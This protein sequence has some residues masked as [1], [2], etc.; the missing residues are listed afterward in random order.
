M[1]CRENTDLG[2][3]VLGALSPGERSALERHLADCADCKEELVLLAPLPGLLRHT[4]LGEVH[5]G[6]RS[7][8]GGS[9]PP[10][11]RT[12]LGAVRRRTVLVVTALL[13][14]V[15]C[16]LV[17]VPLPGDEPRAGGPP[18]AVTLSNT[19]PETHVRA[20]VALAAEAWGTSMDVTLSH[21]PPG[22]ICRLV[23][24]SH[25]GRT[26]TSGTWSTDYGGSSGRIPAA[27]SISPQDIDSME[28]V[29]DTDQVLVRIP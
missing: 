28:V 25:E 10:P 5:E 9:A 3:Y 22:R 20:S 27:T 19:D 1:T 15:V 16:A 12:R 29:T 26:E 7:A 6:D 11:P 23:V 2:A 14:A 8:V 4:P 13:A 21:L 18:G 17:V 24:R